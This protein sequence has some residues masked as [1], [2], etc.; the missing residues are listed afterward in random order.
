MKLIG[1]L[2]LKAGDWILSRSLHHGGDPEKDV[3]QGFVPA[4]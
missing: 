1:L 3:L 4:K 2:E